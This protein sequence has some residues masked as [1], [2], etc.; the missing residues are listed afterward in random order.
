MKIPFVLL[1]IIVVCYSCSPTNLMSLSV[2]EPASVSLP[3]NAKSAAVV[4]RSRAA[5]DSRTVDAIHRTISLE[6]R[7]LQAEGA[8]A[9]LTGPTD[10]LI[11]SN[12]FD[13]VKPPIISISAPTAREY[14]PSTCPGTPWKRYAGKPCGCLVLPRT[15]RCRIQGRLKRLKRCGARTGVQRENTGEDRVIYDPSTRSVLDQFVIYRGPDLPGWQYSFGPGLLCSAKKEAV[16]KAG[17]RAG[18]IMYHALSPILLR[19]S[20]NYYVRG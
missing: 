20:R 1:G 3:P 15:F 7:E 11:R 16:I 8:G 14:S 18:Q 9:S 10:A 5:D 2:T 13:S 12:R 17:N 6:S 19:V 4:N